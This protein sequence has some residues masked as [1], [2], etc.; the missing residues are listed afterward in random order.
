MYCALKLFEKGIKSL[1][2]DIK[3]KNGLDKEFEN[4]EKHNQDLVGALD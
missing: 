1:R 2:D 4:L 3:K